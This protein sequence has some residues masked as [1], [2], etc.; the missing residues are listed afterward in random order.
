MVTTQA[1]VH[2][3]CESN[4]KN[5]MQQE[6]S[7]PKGFLCCFALLYMTLPILNNDSRK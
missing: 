6:H 4:V 3:M 5:C 2:R 7:I 1:F